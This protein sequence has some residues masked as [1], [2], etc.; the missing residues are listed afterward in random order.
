M[1]LNLVTGAD[2]F[3][4]QH[5]VAELLGRGEDV[6]GAVQGAEPK[7]TTLPAAAADRVHW[8]TLELE[9]EKSVRGVARSCVADR[10]FH[11]AGLSSPADSLADPVAPMRVN[12]IGTLY[13][14][15]ELAMMSRG[16]G[17]YPVLL[18]SGS[19][20]VYGAAAARF[21]P[22]SEE[23]P[24]E[25]LNPY[26]VSKVAQE[27]FARQ[28][29]RSHGLSVVVTRSFNHTGPGQRSTFVA[30]QLAAQVQGMREAGGAGTVKVGDPT[31]R[32]DFTD[33]RDVV[34][35]YVALTESGEPGG[36]YN[37]CSGSAYAV[38]DLLDMLARAAGVGVTV[39]TEVGRARPLDAPLVVGSNARLAAAT[40]WTPK[41]PIERSLSDLLAWCAGR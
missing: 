20:H 4:G 2:G 23:H 33:V 13:L 24:L 5:L 12:A 17:H 30:P 37:V 6:V 1:T 16:S 28:F 35:A 22:L 31:V 11:L 29:H 34:E 8:V 19:G 32:R 41:I 9:Q 40:G 3:V 26:G 38:G 21:Q 39:E 36:V 7:L 14:L 10:I 27:M 15:D 18:I 25:P